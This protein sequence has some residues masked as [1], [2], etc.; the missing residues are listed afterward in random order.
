MKSVLLSLLL[1]TSAYAQSALT[2]YVHDTTGQT[3][4]TPLPAI[5]QLNSTA[6]GSSSPL[7]LKGINSSTNT[8]YLSTSYVSNTAGTT[9]LNPNFSLTA[10]YAGLTMPP[11]GSVIFT[12]NFAPVVTGPLTGYLQVAY[13]IQQTGCTF[14]SAPRHRLP[15]RHL[16]R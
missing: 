16:H 13:Q 10:L 11:G 5:Y 8:I 4:D 1:A 6:E 3:A 2:F 12:V 7:V 9:D 15:G 14:N